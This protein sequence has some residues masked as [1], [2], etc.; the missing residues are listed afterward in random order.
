MDFCTGAINTVLNL[1]VMRAVDYFF[2]S[3][4]FTARALAAEDPDFGHS[5][6]ICPMPPQ[7][8]QRL[9]SKRRFLSSWVSFPSFPSFS[10]ID[11]NAGF[12]VLLEGP[13]LLS[14]LGVWCGLLGPGLGV[15]EVGWGFLSFLSDLPELDG[16]FLAFSLE[17][18]QYLASIAWAAVRS[19]RR[20]DGLWGFWDRTSLMRSASPV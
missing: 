14:G 7:N 8:I 15:T 18:S 9:L 3:S 17:R 5:L 16:G 6:A 13:V 2:G 1:Y 11:L 20:V 10:V 12:G 4:V 19:S